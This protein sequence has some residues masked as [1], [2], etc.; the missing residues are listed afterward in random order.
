MRWIASKKEA[1]SMSLQQLNMPVEDRTSPYLYGRQALERTQWHVT[2][3]KEKAD[4]GSTQFEFP[5]FVFVAAS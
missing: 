3:T 1:I 2:Q 4:L 5:T